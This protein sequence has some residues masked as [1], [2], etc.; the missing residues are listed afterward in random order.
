MDSYVVVFVIVQEV[1]KAR[2]T[3]PVVTIASLILRNLIHYLEE[4]AYYRAYQPAV[5]PG[6]R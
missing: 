5:K 2:L 3:C 4:Y 1:E 6:R